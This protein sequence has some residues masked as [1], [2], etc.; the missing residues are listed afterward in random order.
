MSEEQSLSIK[1][2]VGIIFLG[3]RCSSFCRFLYLHSYVKPYCYIFDTNL[4][5]AKGS[6]VLS[7]LPLRCEGCKK[8]EEHQ[9]E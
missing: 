2:S 6:S 3:N 8:T 7:N 4:L 9:N 5:E 1:V